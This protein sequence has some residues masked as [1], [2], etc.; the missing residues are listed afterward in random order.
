MMTKSKKVEQD[1]KD[2]YAK[3][4]DEFVTQLARLGVHPRVVLKAVENMQKESP[5]E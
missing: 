4:M 1:T 2:V 3:T 5:N